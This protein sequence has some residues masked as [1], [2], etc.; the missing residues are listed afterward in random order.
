MADMESTDDAAGPL[1]GGLRAVGAALLRLP[2][3]VGLVL[4]AAWAGAIW[5]LSDTSHPLPVAPPVPLYLNNL[6]HAPL[7]GVLAFLALIAL[8]RRGSPPWPRIDRRTGGLVLA[9]VGGWSLLDEWHQSWVPGR[10]A[11]LGDVLTDF[12]GAASVL[13]VAHTLGRPRASAAL[14]LRSL[15]LGLV[16]CAAAAAVATWIVPAPADLQGRGATL[17]ASPAPTST[18]TAPT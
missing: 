14:V 8:P 12:V 11:S 7:F 15:A 9:V 1:V 2:R 17:P 6:A 3:W 4:S 13:L 18:P 16:A 5:L 10:H